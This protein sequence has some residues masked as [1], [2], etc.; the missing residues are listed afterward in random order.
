M[1]GDEFYQM[2]KCS[3]YMDWDHRS[4][5]FVTREM[6]FIFSSTTYPPK[7]GEASA[8]KNL[9]FAFSY[10]YF[11]L[12]YFFWLWLG[13]VEVPGPWMETL[14]QKGPKPVQWQRQT[15]KLL[16][17]K[18]TPEFKSFISWNS[19][20]FHTP[21]W[22][23]PLLSIIAIRYSYFPFSWPGYHFSFNFFFFFFF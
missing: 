17:H 18:G 23:Q 9:K 8:I 12:F 22:S 10:F 14:P 19:V 16:C 2:I 11:I 20:F 6:S 4:W 13:H 21:E 1:K 15:L 7:L 3:F 5:D